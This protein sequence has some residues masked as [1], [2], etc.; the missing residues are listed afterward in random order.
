MVHES[1]GDQNVYPFIGTSK[2]CLGMKK[3]DWTCR[4]CHG[5]PNLW[6]FCWKWQL[7]NWFWMILDVLPQLS[8]KPVWS[9]QPEQ[10]TATN[11]SSVQ[12]CGWTTFSL[13]YKKK[14]FLAPELAQ[15]NLYRKTLNTLQY[16]V[17]WW[18]CKTVNNMKAYLYVKPSTYLSI[19]P[20]HPSI[21]LSYLSICLFIYL[22]L[23]ASTIC[24]MELYS[25]WRARY[26]HI[27]IT[28]KWENKDPIMKL[29][30]IYYQYDLWLY[31]YMYQCA[32]AY[33][34]CV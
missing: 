10:T 4:I 24:C 23:N 18:T 34:Q 28:H 11:I 13:C 6:K 14:K 15:G 33:I 20:S 9:H 17:D 27:S 7:N 31:I 12:P 16:L 29:W 19:Y 26:N 21:Y 30:L 3:Y 22:A 8:D 32:Y 5:Y 25:I 2:T 1:I